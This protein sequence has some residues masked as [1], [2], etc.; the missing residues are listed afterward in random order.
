MQEIVIKE[1]KNGGGK[2]YINGVEIENCLE[3][4]VNINPVEGT[5]VKMEFMVEKTSINYREL[6]KRGGIQ[7]N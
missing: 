7:W 1:N 3:I 5:K 2:V 6:F 4:N